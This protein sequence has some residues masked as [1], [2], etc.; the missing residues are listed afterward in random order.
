[1]ITAQAKKLIISVYWLS[2]IEIVAVFIGF[3]ND[4][5]PNILLFYADVTDLIAFFTLSA[6]KGFTIKSFAPA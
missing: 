4:L 2:V 5:S 6:S 3:I 1:M